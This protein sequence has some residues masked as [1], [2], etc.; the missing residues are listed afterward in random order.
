HRFRQVVTYTGEVSRGRFGL[1]LT[2]L[3]DINVDGV[4]DFAVGAPYGGPDGNGAVFIYHG[5]QIRGGELI[6]EEL[7][8]PAQVIYASD[9][10]VGQAISTFG[11]SLSGGMDMDDNLYPDL[12]VGAYLSDAAVLLKSRPIV[13]LLNHSLTFMT[14]GKTID[15]EAT[16]SCRNSAT[17]SVTC[18]NLQFCVAYGGVGLPRNIDLDVQYFLDNKVN[19]PRLFF[20]ETDSTKREERMRLSRES[21][22]CKT[23]QVYV[24]PTLTDK[25]SPISAEV[26]LALVERSYSRT[27]RS[28]VP[29]LN[30]RQKL[31]LGDAITIQKNCGPDNV[32]IP[33]LRLTF[34][35]PERFVFRKNEQL[36]V[37]VRVENFGEDAFEARV[38]LSVPEGLLYNIFQAK[39][40]TLVTCSPRTQGSNTTV[41]CDIGN[42]LSMEKGVHFTI[43]LD[44]KMGALQEPQLQFLVV[45]NTTNSEKDGT[46]EDNTVLTTVTVDID[47]QLT[48]Y[49]SSSPEN[50]E[51]N[52][53]LYRES[54]YTHEEHLG[55]ELT[56]V[57]A[58]SN[59]GPTPI[60]GNE[61]V[62]LW[63]TQTLNGNYLLYLLEQPH[64]TGPAKCEF[65]PDVNPLGLQLNKE[66][67]SIK[68]LKA[69]GQGGG[70]EVV[71][72]G[73][74]VEAETSSSSSS[75]G[76]EVVVQSG[77]GEVVV[78]GGGRE[79]IRR[80]GGGG[81]STYY[82]ESET[83][84]YS[85]SGGGGGGNSSSSS[86]SSSSTSY[87]SSSSSHSSS[88][89]SSSGSKH[90]SSSSS[91]HNDLVR[92]TRE[93]RRLDWEEEIN[94]CGPTLCTKIRCVAGPLTDINT[95]HIYVR[96]RMV[97]TTLLEDHQMYPF[98]DV[99]I[100][101]KVVARVTS[102]PHSINP[103]LLPVKSLEVA[104][105]VAP[106]KSL[107]EAPEVPWWVILLATLAGI[108]ILAIII[109]ILWKCGYFKR[110]RPK[111]HQARQDEAARPLNSHHNN[112]Y[113]N[114]NNY[115]PG[116]QAL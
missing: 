77:G 27:R 74:V 19:E 45:A 11:W 59:K 88:S 75:S 107:D 55:P 82:E 18:V 13:Q 46:Q 39:D 25:L 101:S 3:K 23:Y 85:S 79:G 43:L 54:G 52:H 80:G 28:L 73:G 110:N 87:S 38:Y 99:K 61:V 1:S 14:E 86:S 50:I 98:K 68:L 37:D 109:L 60:I 115:H 57:Y 7:K 93:V 104:T 66:A 69:Q 71:V 44:Q 113:N 64:T 56:H 30:Q 90:S 2:T 111:E 105:P 16:S 21:Q 108:L 22:N 17:L 15:L 97:M 72:E 62:I 89:S 100:F 106:A 65:V 42:P 78:E 51:Y 40:N 67:A 26:S 95:V 63:P 91:G 8:K 81:S 29:I 103:E 6:S 32:C 58:L 94:N 49:G 114:H 31:K 4:D 33:D 92:R 34:T 5:F 53:T 76:E 84:Y 83:R 12:L 20:L 116:D 10:S 36:E 70:G 102:L 9:V 48:L 112:G 96:S 24:A 41:V 35:A 47:T